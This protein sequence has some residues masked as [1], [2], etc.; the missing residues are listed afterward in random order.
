MLEIKNLTK[1]FDEKEKCIAVNNVSLHVE[2]GD[3]ISI[4]GYSGSGKST[5]LNLIS[6]LL[7]PTSGSILF[8]G[9]DINK[10][11]DKQISDI[12]NR[13]IGY[14]L[15]GNSLL[16]NLT[17]AEN[18]L[19]PATFYYDDKEYDVEKVMNEVGIYEIKDRYPSEISG[20]EAKRCA[21]ARSLLLN[22][23]LL[24]ADEPVSDLDPENTKIIMDVFSNYVNK[25]MSI[26]MV[27]H[28]IETTK[29]GNLV[30]RMNKGELIKER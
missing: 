19:L 27:T 10:L 22:P 12:R 9:A 28:N 29:Y 8:Q 6:G 16:S 25:G 17:V 15:Q 5:L 4:V 1:E 13:G 30:Y 20:G 23:K 14:V 11:K 7:T 3:F 2:K 24:L 26:I 18:I 21:I